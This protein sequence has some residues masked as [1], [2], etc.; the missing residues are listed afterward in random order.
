M[1][2]SLVACALLKDIQ[3]RTM[4]DVDFQDEQEDIKKNIE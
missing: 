4:E 3:N 2:T 1:T